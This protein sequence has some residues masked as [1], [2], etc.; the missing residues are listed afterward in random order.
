MAGLEEAGRFALKHKY[1]I[2]TN[3]PYLIKNGNYGVVDACSSTCFEKRKKFKSSI[4]GFGS[5]IHDFFKCQAQLSDY[6]RTAARA[7]VMFSPKIY[8]AMSF[9]QEDFKKKIL[10][11]ETETGH[12]KFDLALQSNWEEILDGVCDFDIC[13][14]HSPLI[15]EGEVDAPRIL[16]WYYRGLPYLT[17]RIGLLLSSH[18]LPFRR[19]DCTV[20]IVKENEL[21]H[22]TAGSLFLSGANL[23]KFPLIYDKFGC[24]QITE[25]SREP[26]IRCGD[27][28]R[29]VSIYEQYLR[30]FVTKELISSLAAKAV[31]HVDRHLNRQ[32]DT[33][34][35]LSERL[36][37]LPS[38]SIFLT[39]YP[40]TPEA[41]ALARL[42]MQRGL[43]TIAFQHGISREINGD[44]GDMGVENSSANLT[45]VYNQTAKLNSDNTAYCH[46]KTEIASF[47]EKGKKLRKKLRVLS[48]R[49]K[50]ILYLSTNVYRGNI[51]SLNSP[52]T[53]FE[54]FL[55]EST[56]IREVL[57]KLPHPV[58][59]KPYPFQ[60]RYADQDPIFNELK[61]CNNIEVLKSNIDARYFIRSPSLIVTSRATSTTGWAIMSRCPLCFID[62]P[63][64]QPLNISLVEHFSDA[65]FYFRLQDP[66]SIQ[67]L[68]NFLSLPISEI[69]NIWRQKKNH[70]EMFISKYISS[71]DVV[72]SKVASKFLIKEYINLINPPY[73]K[74]L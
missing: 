15:D 51:A 59:Y 37:N 5:K 8:D 18:L 45:F 74:W 43:P 47:P 40:G 48:L 64:Q 52:R 36:S 58:S 73:S 38:N 1:Q 13:N 50:K 49:T 20:Y 62:I 24:S 23:K 17:Y 71:K 44:H 69:E 29:L 72:G 70:R 61:L 16:R 26:I 60:V 57:E 54:N 39:N 3:A 22:E 21:L 14:V 12:E 42:A 33:T 27:R 68:R 65:F 55:S 25:K 30:H 4:E 10:L 6:R 19:T 34:I 7:A 32:R 2:R 66:K 11:I 28:S 41:N 31:E 46:G 67:D 35:S 63:D 9:R 53:D 56:I